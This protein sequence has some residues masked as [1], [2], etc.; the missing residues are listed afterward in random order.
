M[1]FVETDTAEDLTDSN[2]ITNLNRGGLTV[3]KMST[4]HFVH[5]A[6][7]VIIDYN[8]RC[9][10]VP[11]SQAIYGNNSHMAIIHKACLTLS[12]IFLK[13]FI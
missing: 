1:A 7:K 3:P 10:R 5:A 2:F 12:N 8:L 9:C 6:H 4:V 13:A 11:L